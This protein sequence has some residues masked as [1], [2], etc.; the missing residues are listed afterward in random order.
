MSTENTNIAESLAR[1]LPKT[2]VL[3]SVPEF[4]GKENDA[5]AQFVIAVPNNSKLETLDM[6]KLLPNPRR[7]KGTA[8]MGD[9]D[10]FIAYVNKFAK[11]GTTV[12]C[13]FNPQT[14]TLGF[15]AVIDEHSPIDA[16]WRGH[17]AVYTPAM[18]IEWMNWKGQNTK[19]MSQVEFADFLEKNENDIA[20]IEGFPTSLQMHAMAT[21]FHAR[22]E[23]SI[24]STARLQDGSVRLTYIND[25]DSETQETMKVFDKF[26]IGIPVFWS[27]PAL[28][29]D[30]K[31][32]PVE[33]YRIDA[34]L[35]YRMANAKVSFWYELI[36]PDRT[37]QLAAL[38]L[39][40]QVKAGI[41]DVPLRMGS[42]A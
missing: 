35:R 17:Q 23:Q 5:P 33:A 31:P 19:V 4:G 7:A 9:Q 37:H 42:F 20:T 32:L 26:V 18:S 10:S 34:R 29:D 36:R 25:A 30:G 15:R 40:Q 16:G 8:T 21:E 27:V 3:F 12:W 11:H 28:G 39:I 14:A 6:E 24:K 1:V 41:G 2:D 38:G 22:S 13:D